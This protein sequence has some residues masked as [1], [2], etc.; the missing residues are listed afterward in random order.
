MTKKTLAT[1]TVHKVPADLRKVLTIASL[2]LQVPVLAFFLIVA[3]I[4]RDVIPLQNLSWIV[5]MLAH[6]SVLPLLYGA[7]VYKTRRI[8]DSEIM[9]RHE[10]VVPFFVV[11]VVYGIY[12]AETILFG[13][14]GIFKTLALHFFLTALLVSTI[15]LFWKVSVH[16]AGVTQFVALLVLF[17]GNQA[18]FL[19][20][21]I[22][23]T[24]WLRMKMRSHDVWQVLGG[25]AVALLS[26]SIAEE[27]RIQ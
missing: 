23:L 10:R 22:V 17:A 2:L 1:G 8:S 21:L 6:L 24:G 27:L 14:P 13:A 4:W 5:V 20:P 12:L 3:L 7:F 26:F 18:L 15:T 19:S 11:T 16:T 25:I 9:T